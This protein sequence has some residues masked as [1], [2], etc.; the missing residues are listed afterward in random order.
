MVDSLLPDLENGC[1]ATVDPVLPLSLRTIRAC[2][3]SK[4]TPRG[5]TRRLLRDVRLRGFLRDGTVALTRKQMSPICTLRVKDCSTCPADITLR[6]S[7]IVHLNETAKRFLF[8]PVKYSLIVLQTTVGS[9][10]MHRLGE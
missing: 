3:V 8:S 6:V 4:L 7:T 1:T 10:S 5:S 9:M 2:V